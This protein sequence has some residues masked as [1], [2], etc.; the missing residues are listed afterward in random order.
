[1]WMLLATLL[2]LA[3]TTKPMNDPFLIE[4][5]DVFRQV[6]PQDARVR[7]LA[8]GF[9]FLEGPCWV[10][11][12]LY[13]SDQVQRKIFTWSPDAGVGVFREQSHNANGNTLDNAGHMVTCE[14]DTR[15]VSI[16]L[17]AERSV[18]V[19]RFKHDGKEA[20]FNSPNDVVVKRDGTIWFTDPPYGIPPEK[21]AKEMEYGGRWVFRYD[22]KDESVTPVARDFDMPN[23][24]CFSP[25][26]S[27]LYVA[28]SGEPRHVR[29]FAVNADNTLAGGE[30]FCKIDKGVPDGMRC[31]TAGRLF[32]T[33]GDGIHI[34]APD[35]RRIGKI[36]VPETPAN[37]TFG[38][39][40]NKTLFI[41][42]Q[43]GLY[44]IDL[45]VAGAK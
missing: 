15:L 32:S 27:V 44:A 17:G 8:D 18:L 28:D 20:R 7:Q 24:L 16:T 30:V 43:K 34:F 37:C 29:R 11:G 14:T 38:G 3:P 1:M 19:D 4:D 2:T 33:A 5:A 12:R 45:S 35:G 42:A 41:T 10:G 22:P 39:E 36:L 13:F 23:G 31:D 40:G 21:R 9:R 6:V 26:E 25:D